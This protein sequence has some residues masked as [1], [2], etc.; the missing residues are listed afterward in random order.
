MSGDQQ[1]WKA[2]GTWLRKQGFPR[3]S[4]SP[5]VFSD[6]GRGLMAT[7]DFSAGDV[8]IRVPNHLLITI[9]TVNDALNGELCRQNWPLSEHA[10]LALFLA[11]HKGDQG[12]IN[13]ADHGSKWQPYV[14]VIPS[15]FDTVA[16]NMPSELKACCPKIVQDAI[17]RVCVQFERIYCLSN[18][19]S[20][21]CI[22]TCGNLNL[23]RG[24]NSE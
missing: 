15:N 14:N 18:A 9:T 23:A 19:K 24:K 13:S 8:L 10:S 2:F 16:A 1:H 12:F 5:A 6:S 22:A 3:A 20:L 21:C 4:L 7:K 11:L 17:I